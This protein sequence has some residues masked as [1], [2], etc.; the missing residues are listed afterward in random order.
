MDKNKYRERMKKKQQQIRRRKMMRL[1]TYVVGAIL[2]L[3]FIIRGVIF[4]IVNR[5]GGS[6][7]TQSEEV[8]AETTDP[9]A[10]VRQPLK[11]QADLQ[12]ATQMTPGWHEDDS[13]KWYQNTDGTYFVSGFQEIDGDTY[14]F[15]ENGYIQTGWIS[16]GSKDYY[17]DE[18]GI[19][20]SSVRRK[21][22]AL[23]YDDGPGEYTDQLLDCLEENG[24]H[25]T[26]FM[27]GE[28]VESYASEIQ[29]MV[30]LGCE[31]GNHSW[32]H[33]NLDELSVEETADQY[34]RTDEALMEVCGQK[35]TVARCPYGNGNS[36]KFAA[37]GKPFFM[38]SLDSLDWSYRDVDMDY[39]AVMEGDLTDGS[40][41]LMHDIHPESVEASL[42]II[43]DLIAQ[44]YKLVTVS[45]LAEAKGV[46]LQYASY[47]DFWD[48][49]L[50]AG[51]V[52]GYEGNT[53]EDSSD[54][55]SEEEVSDEEDSGDDSSD[56]DYSDDDYSDEDY[57][58]EG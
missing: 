41:I 30:E 7:T 18:N 37:V 42:Q 11:G 39:Q 51:L 21:M 35:S 14:S 10:A 33:P 57:S 50:A 16:V 15:D 2:L 45:E 53:T 28:H 22:L 24:A 6:T 54:S 26:F 5:L 20:D 43:P 52:A 1:A 58:D 47:S 55:S 49:S 38:W 29:R 17:F 46:D 36:E 25:A 13:G 23:T 8:Q 31:L 56:E 27:L 44:G 19:Y 4:P 34:A 12:K 9:T 40:I 3:V 32:D 48:S